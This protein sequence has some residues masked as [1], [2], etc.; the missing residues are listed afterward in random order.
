MP[1]RRKSFPCGHRGYGSKCHACEAEAREREQRQR[2]RAERQ[3][4]FDADPIDL[5]HLPD[6]I[7]QKAREVI[8]A[9][10]AGA[11]WRRLGGRKLNNEPGIIRFPL[12]YSY[13]LV[14]R[15]T[16]GGIVPLKAMSHEK[17]NTASFAS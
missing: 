17:Y 7:V 16:A 4:L 9:L 5:S 14:C 10:A 8:Q 15:Q 6:P 3:A 1:G 11:P 13:R 12:G 2:I